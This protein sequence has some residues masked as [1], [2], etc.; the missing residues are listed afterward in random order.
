MADV[1]LSSPNIPKPGNEWPSPAHAVICA[2]DWLGFSLGEIHQR[3]TASQSTIRGILHQEHFCRA[4]KNRVYK[5]CLMSAREIRRCIC[6][7]ARDWS[8]HRL[9]FEQ[10]KTQLG[11]KASAQTIQ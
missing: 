4:C 5:P 11:I 2:L 10:V 1:I 3:T 9:T 7:I 8:T 6:H